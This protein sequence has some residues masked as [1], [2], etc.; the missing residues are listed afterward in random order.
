MIKKKSIQKSR[1][2]RGGTSNKGKGS[3]KWGKKLKRFKKK[4]GG[5]GR[6]GGK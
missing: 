6:K 5:K 1:K 3:K 2:V 4:F